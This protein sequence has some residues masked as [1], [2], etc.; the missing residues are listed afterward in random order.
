MLLNELFEHLAFLHPSAMYA[1]VRL[2]NGETLEHSIDAVDYSDGVVNLISDEKDAAAYDTG[3]ADGF[4][5]GLEQGRED[6]ALNEKAG[7][8]YPGRT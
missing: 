2:I 1:R 3:Y 8:Q 6:A 5:R 7:Q 4:T